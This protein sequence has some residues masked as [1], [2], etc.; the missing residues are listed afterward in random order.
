MCLSIVRKRAPA[1]MMVV[2]AAMTDDASNDAGLRNSRYRYVNSVRDRAFERRCVDA[3][4]RAHGGC[5]W[6]VND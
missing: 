6:S 2:N 3:R 5:V 4:L 1:A